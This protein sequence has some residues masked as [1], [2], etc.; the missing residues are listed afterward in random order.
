MAGITLGKYIDIRASVR[1]EQLCALPWFL[2]AKLYNDSRK[3]SALT[4]QTDLSWKL[5]PNH[6]GNRLGFHCI[7]CASCSIVRAPMVTVTAVTRSREA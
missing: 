3:D 5:S 2:L 1:S 7:Y 4:R 6:L